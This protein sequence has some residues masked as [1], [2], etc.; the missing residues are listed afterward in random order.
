MP[1]LLQVSNISSYFVT[2]PDDIS[3]MSQS[4]SAA[5]NKSPES[6]GDQIIHG[7]IAQC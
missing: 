4:V 2:L 6:Q 7:V 3:D 1:L 5:R